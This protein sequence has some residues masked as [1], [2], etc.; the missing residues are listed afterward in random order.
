MTALLQAFDLKKS[1]GGVAAVDGVSIAVR[2]GA[3]AGLIGP[4]GAGKSTLFG[5][6]AGALPPDA[7]RIELKGQDVTGWPD[8][9]IARLGLTRT[10]Q[11]ARELDRLTVLENLLLAVPDQ[12]G[13]QLGAVFLSP[14]RV[15]AAQ[16]ASVAQ[17]REILSMVGLAKKEDSLAKELSGGQKKLLELGRA[18]MT[19]ADVI[20]LDE[21]GAGVAPALLVELCD[22]IARLN[23]EH[24]KTFLL[25]EHNMSVIRRLCER[26]TVMANG[27]ILIE[28][29]FDEVRRDPRVIEAYLGVAA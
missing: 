20:L 4:N 26:V 3:L 18:L 9:R 2:P 29:S 7:G 13:E 17:A 10:F 11:L 28:G 6:L 22:L 25:V 27:K 16:A 15:R 14:R 24:G 23:R 12:P 5:L 1:F 19:G 8:Y 21:I